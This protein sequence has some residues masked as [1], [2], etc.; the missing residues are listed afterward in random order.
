[1]IEHATSNRDRQARSVWRAHQNELR[2]QRPHTPQER[3][4]RTESNE[5]TDSPSALAKARVRVAQLLS[6]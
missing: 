6:Q 4:K 5:T 3:H 2:K 1:M